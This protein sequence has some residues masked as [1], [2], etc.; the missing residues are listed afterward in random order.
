M[1]IAPR[2][3]WFANA[4]P[5]SSTP[6]TTTS[7]RRLMEA[8][9]VS[10]A[11]SARASGRPRRA[12]NGRPSGGIRQHSRR[13][14]RCCGR[15]RRWPED[16]AARGGEKGGGANVVDAEVWERY[17]SGVMRQA[18][19]ILL[20]LLLQP[21]FRSETPWKI[22]PRGPRLVSPGTTHRSRPDNPESRLSTPPSRWRRARSKPA[23]AVRF[24]RRLGYSGSLSSETW[25]RG[26]AER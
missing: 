18:T 20:M 23:A 14:R 21:V 4:A 3:A 17:L 12:S 25:P 5:R 7:D 11:R 26:S 6:G 10:R 19:C 1:P 24:A 16:S 15:S 13:H 22:R 2:T 8:E 9:D